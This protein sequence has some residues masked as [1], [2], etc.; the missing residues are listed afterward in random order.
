MAGPFDSRHPLVGLIDEVVRTGARLRSV[1][2]ATRRETGLGESEFTVL[3]AVVE[4]ARAPTVAQI[5]RSLGRPRQLVQRAANALVATGLIETAENPDHKRAALL[6]A[7]A[8]GT[9]LKRAADA[10]G[11]AIAA[12]LGEGLDLAQMNA[13]TERLGAVR[14]DLEARLRKDGL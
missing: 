6:V 2:A 10:R 8:R 7:T 14:K 1:F 11:D 3:N 5:G 9:A 13:V 4:A 12:R